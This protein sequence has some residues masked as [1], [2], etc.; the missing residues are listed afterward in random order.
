MIVRPNNE[1]DRETE[2]QYMRSLVITTAK[3]A[4][5]K[6]TRVRTVLKAHERDG[7]DWPFG[8][9][10]IARAAR[11]LRIPLRYETNGGPR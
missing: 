9:D 3:V 11:G 7:D 2:R 5:E 8:G 1:T 6:P 10:E 4:I